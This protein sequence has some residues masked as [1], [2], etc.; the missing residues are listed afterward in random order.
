MNEEIKIEKIWTEFKQNNPN[1]TANEFFT[2]VSQQLNCG[3]QE[4][5]TYAS[6][7]F[8]SE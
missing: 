1:G 2:L 5:K 7:L 4:A 6:H 8:L 3:L